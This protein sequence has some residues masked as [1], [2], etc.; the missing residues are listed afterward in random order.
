MKRGEG[1]PLPHLSSVFCPLNA[2]NVGLSYSAEN[3]FGASVGVG[4]C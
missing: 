4:L 2:V 3:G 1:F